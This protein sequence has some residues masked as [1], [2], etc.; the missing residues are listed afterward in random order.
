MGYDNIF[1]ST[2][3]LG[4]M[5]DLSSQGRHRLQ[6]MSE[7]GFWN[8]STAIR[9]LLGILFAAVLFCFLHFRDVRVLNLELGGRAPAFVVSQINFEFFDQEATWIAEQEAMK[10]I[11]GLF[12]IDERVIEE[13][14]REFRRR[15][16]EEGGWRRFLPNS[17]YE[18]VSLAASKVIEALNELRVT[19]ERTFQRWLQLKM[20]S[21]NISIVSYTPAE[22]WATL[23]ESVWNDILERVQL[24][25]GVSV[26]AVEYVLANF[27]EKQWRLEQDHSAQRKLKQ[28]VKEE[29][30]P[31]YKKVNAGA[32]LID[33]DEEVKERHLAMMKA[34]KRA[35]KEQRKLWTPAALSGTFLMTSLFVVLLVVYLMRFQP[36]IFASNQQL[37]L[38][39][40]IAVLTLLL[41]KFAERVLFEASLT[42]F[43]VLA[44]PLF[45]VFPAVLLSTL[46]PLDVAAIF[47]MSLMVILAIALPV[48]TF[49]FIRVNFVAIIVALLQSDR[50][51]R[52]RSVF[53]TA[54]KIWLCCSVVLLGSMLYNLTQFSWVSFVEH[55]AIMLISVGVSAI[56]IITFLPLLESSFQVM[57]DMTL[58]Q[59]M[60]PNRELLRR[61]AIEAP[62]TYQHSLLVAHLSE[63]AAA[64]IGARAL[65]CRVS[66]LY[67]DIGK[68]AFPHYF[69]ENQQG[70]N[71]HHLLTPLESAQVIISHVSEGVALAHKHNLPEAFIDIIKE[72]HGTNLVYYF[73][74]KQCEQVGE[75][76]TVDERQFRYGGPKPRSK[77][78]GIIMISDCLEA[79]SRSLE[80]VNEETVTHL[81]EGIVKDLIADAQLSQCQLSFSELTMV[82]KSLVKTMVASSHSRIK[83]PTRATVS[84]DS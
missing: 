57:T 31:T 34:M 84:D 14:Y 63:G 30:A 41:S 16:T 76:E 45:I 67:H 54:L 43:D 64:A 32:R 37:A 60:D 71:V 58:M 33:K 74:R 50:L 26:G 23:P 66:G 15:L 46:F 77:E 5:S 20:P 28:H 27:K 44:N 4:S 69:A 10:E 53:P 39:L 12:S 3:D 56:L 25:E 13:R 61:L 47:S 18:D 17:S 48:D 73:F 1:K 79:A 21:K 22:E 65:Y 62:G 51:S 35:L 8:R 80:Q 38:G 24:E 9:G 59:Y 52:R 7:Y 72:H 36:H 70:I 82:K 81:L 2:I 40:M 78:S 42:G 11:D 6:F 83:Y 68:L 55:S 19:T 29:I 49:S 75:G